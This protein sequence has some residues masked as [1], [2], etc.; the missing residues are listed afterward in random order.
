MQ[1][2]PIQIEP[3]P[4]TIHPAIPSPPSAGD[5]NEA[6]VEELTSPSV[7]DTT[8]AGELFLNV[9][10]VGEVDVFDVSSQRLQQRFYALTV[11]H[12]LEDD[13]KAAFCRQSRTGFALEFSE[14]RGEGDWE[15][16]RED[17]QKAALDRC[18]RLV[19]ASG[20]NPA[21]FSNNRPALCRRM[22][23]A[24]GG[25]PNSRNKEYEFSEH[26]TALGLKEVPLRQS[27]KSRMR[28]PSVW[29]GSRSTGYTGKG[30]KFGLDVVLGSPDKLVST[31]QFFATPRCGQHTGH[32][33]PRRGELPTPKRLLP[34]GAVELGSDV[35][36]VG[37]G[38]DV[39]RRIVRF[40]H[41]AVMTTSTSDYIRRIQKRVSSGNATSVDGMVEA[42]KEDPGTEFIL[43]FD[44][45]APDRR[46]RSDP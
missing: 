30:C 13:G 41:G 36:A 17:I 12:L 22:R 8:W 15:Q 44:D 6:W 35:L 33:R 43:L 14:P 2:I 18:C 24:C 46:Y 3:L 27:R 4:S 19:V 7:E 37:G 23:C 40:K 21:A 34:D 31:M 25:K 9:A 26:N 5:M 16:V 20:A 32:V 1:P 38:S 45:A 11:P 29:G 39:A 10:G 42:L 28:D